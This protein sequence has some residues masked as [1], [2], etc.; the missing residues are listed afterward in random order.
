MTSIELSTKAILGTC[1]LCKSN[2]LTHLL[3]GQ[4]RLHGTPGVFPIVQCQSCSLAFIHPQPALEDI[5]S[6]YPTHYYAY[7]AEKQPNHPPLKRLELYFR[8]RKKA[9]ILS[10]YYNYPRKFEKNL[11]FSFLTLFNKKINDVP[12]YINH[13]KLLDIGCG[14]GTYLLEMKK[15][16][17][18]TQGVELSEGA[19]GVA[20]QSG[21]NV[22][23]GTLEE[24]C[25]PAESI[26]FARMADV[27]EHLPHP[28]HT[29]LE[30]YRILK[31]EGTLLISVPNIRSLTF[32][33]F[34]TYWF[35]LEIPR[36]LFFYTPRSL[37]KLCNDSG[38]HVEDLRVWSD[39]VVD[40][41][42]SFQYWLEERHPKSCAFF[43]RN[44]W[45]LKL[46]R[47]MF[48]PIKWAANQLNYGSAM[49]ITVRK[50]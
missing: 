42:P 30:V 35:P 49:T 17:W 4:D 36:H 16:G 38:F 24:A 29:M 28:T 11:F 25:L 47:K 26:D 1:H 48:S 41:V 43:N 44:K 37:K 6:F 21:L 46:M 14:K 39:N 19:V 31:P 32:K 7:T 8:A 34:G 18:D 12:A 9:E 5:P 13:G 40:I 45:A 27:L 3:D 15:L 50:K 2:K 22:L 33:I 10:K 20:K 23:Q